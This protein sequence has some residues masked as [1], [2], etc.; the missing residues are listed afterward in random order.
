MTVKQKLLFL[1]ATFVLGL[2]AFG[3]VVWTTLEEV[4][5]SGPLYRG[6]VQG[7]DLVADVLP[8]P[9]YVIESYLV[10]LQMLE[11]DDRKALD[12]LVARGRQL[13]ADFESR[14]DYWKRELA[15]G[16]L[17]TALLESSYRPAMEFFERRDRD[18]VPTLLRGERE[19]ATAYVHETLSKLYEQHRT[20]IDQVVELAN[21]RSSAAEQEGHARVGSRRIILFG[22]GAVI[23]LVVSVWGLA[24]GG[25]IHRRIEDTIAVI[26]RVATG[27]LR[28]RVEVT[29]TDEFGRIGTALNTA[30][31]SMSAALSSMHATARDLSAASSQLSNIALQLGA[32]AEEA[33]AQANAAN[34]GADHV[35]RSV[36]TVATGMEEMGAAIKEIA[37]NASE[38]VSVARTAVDTASG[39]VDTVGRLNGSSQQIDR[40]VKL[41][42]AIAEQTHLLA[43]NAAIEAARAG[44]AGRGFAVVANEVKDL[45]RETEKA[46]E[47]ISQ[48]VRVIQGDSRAAVDAIG[49]IRAVINQISDSQ[50]AIAGAVEEQ[51]ATTAEIG[52]GVAD[53]ARSTTEIAGSIGQV[54]QAAQVTTQG[55]IDM[56]GSATLL[57]DLAQRMASLAAH[58]QCGPNEATE[59]RQAA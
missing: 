6:I 51:S 41:I 19:Q 14:H 11:E 35:A 54:A 16:P 52:R 34:G 59:F 44:E 28:P 58:F 40:V 25:S 15:A 20:A 26:E 49:S 38:A 57:A 2:G 47:E 8:P 31:G 10:V 30:L 50:S 43:L 7:K 5:V 32:G 27:D 13:R 22:M 36:E 42:T 48:Q 39:A 55:V 24:I 53:A 18:F 1:V 17:A 3:A 45:A 29:T 56:Q 21:A 9:E 4:Q 37:S 46:T 23:A 33:A 12:R